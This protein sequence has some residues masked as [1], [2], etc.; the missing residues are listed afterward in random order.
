MKK[1]LIVWLVI[2]AVVVGVVL[3][4]SNKDKEGGDS[5]PTPSVSGSPQPTTSP[6]TSVRPPTS[7]TP[8]PTATVTTTPSP[9]ATPTP[10]PTTVGFSASTYLVNETDSMVTVTVTRT[11]SVV[12]ET[13]VSY[14]SEDGTAGNTDYMPVSGTFVFKAGVTSHTF[15][16]Q[17]RDDSQLED[18]ETIVLR[19]S[20]IQGAVAGRTTATITIVDDESQD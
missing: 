13:R 11:G 1:N 19:L 15:D 12:G 18:N 20:G 10:G 2:A 17:I 16:V 3:V 8:V 14:D 7:R 4:V 5:T 6:T 9:T